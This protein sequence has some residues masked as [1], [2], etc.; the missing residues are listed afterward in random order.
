MKLAKLE[1]PIRLAFI[2]VVLCL[3]YLAI[4]VPAGFLE[5]AR[6]RS[7]DGYCRLRNRLWPVPPEV[8]DI[9]L[10]TIDEESQRRLGKKWPWERSILADFLTRVSA[11]SPK[12]VV[13]D[14][15][16]A[17]ASQPSHD[18]ALAQA[19]QKGPPVLLACYMDRNGDPIFPLPLFTEVGGQMGLINKPRDIDMTV[20]KLFAGIRV[21]LHEEP[22]YSIEVRSA[23]LARQLAIDQLRLDLRS[24]T[25]GSTRIPLELPSAMAIN[26]L[27]SLRQI[28]RVSFWQV[29][30]GEVEPESIRDKILLVGSATEIT[31]DIYPT[32]LGLMPGVVIS[33]NGILTIL[34]ERFVRPPRLLPVLLVGWIF[35]TSILL[36]TTGAPLAVGALAAVA[37]TGVTILIGFICF[38]L[39]NY[40]TESL[41]ILLLGASAW[42][43]GILYRYL[44]LVAD[45]LRL[46][47]HVVTDPVTGLHTSRYFRLRLEALWPGGRASR[48]PVAL[49]VVRFESPAE[50][51]Q[52]T[53]WNE[54]HGRIRSFADAL[55][56]LQPRRALIGHLGEDRLGILLERTSL[57]QGREWAQR[58]QQ[59]LAQANRGS[60]QW[61]I[62]LAATEQ[63]PIRT[64][65]ALIRAAESAAARAK[66]KGRALL[67]VFD[68]AADRTALEGAEAAV[69]TG[70]QEPLEYVAGELED[71]NRAL[72]KALADLRQAH[73]E[74]ESNFLEVTKALV[75]ALETKDEYTAGHLE[76]VSRYSTRLAEVLGLPQDAL[77]AV[78]EASLL[79][80]IGKI[81]LP[82][83]VLHK[84]GPL[85][86]E[87]KNV[88]K[89]HLSMGARILEPMKFF[90]PI[91]TLIYHHHERYDGRGY[92]HGLTGEFIP[93]GAQ[94]IAIA[95]AFDAMTTNRGYNKPLTGQEALT[96]IR[97]GSGTQFNP[98]YVEAFTRLIEKEGPQLAGYHAA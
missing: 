55:Q 4:L 74:M 78:R 68:P 76:R 56:R 84:V 36:I 97:K 3:A 89:Q 94:V 39:L 34:S 29:T 86:E 37:L 17:G 67:E 48:W 41:S 27:V 64:P 82:D 46:H 77:E 50:M 14:L 85:T 10:V 28:P 20:R 96:E 83:E 65:G 58:L 30:R 24:L 87:E 98:A 6:L 12:M 93:T 5:G 63:G 22:L 15:V 42:G 40:R 38:A 72:E 53:D 11:S 80:D 60:A 61:G 47:R 9:L 54:V 75:M 44:L 45:L 49:A 2:G 31:H 88:I 52:Q 59:D 92:P 73:R 57:E 7:Y 25:I 1:H 90:K 32:P 62:G 21:P 8:R 33:A 43:A 13:F 23:T 71:R 81:G 79:H 19:I 70:S 35:V 16:L 18:Q 26:Y 51:L 91:T 69:I 66:T 95:D